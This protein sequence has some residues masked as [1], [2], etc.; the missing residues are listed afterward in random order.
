M[1]SQLLASI[2]LPTFDAAAT[3]GACLA[4]VARQ[5]ERR[6]ECLIVDDG[7]RDESAAIVG[8]IR[9]KDPRFRWLSGP[10]EGLVP[11][12]NRGLAQCR[13]PLV[14]RMDADDLMHR[15]RLRWQLELM[16]RQPELSGC[17]GHVHLFPRSAV[18]AGMRR[19]QAWLRSI[20]SSATVEREA[21]VE[22]PLAHPTLALRT[23]VLRSFGYRDQG[24]PEDWDLI[25]RLL[26]RG[27]R[28]GVLPRRLLFWRQSPTR[29]SRT[30]PAYSLEAFMACR[31]SFLAQGFLAANEQYVL[32]GYGDTGKALR[33]ALAAHGKSP[34][35]IVELHPGRLGQKIFGAP[36]V[37]PEALTELRP[38]RILVSVAGA[39]ARGQIRDALAAMRLFEGHDYLCCA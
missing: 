34:S 31:A 5:S 12:L 38:A 22:C 27:H 35:H 7:S 17:G 2:L 16:T 11:T 37:A 26:A 4:S 21:F 33:K 3:L 19:Y 15:H 6:F 14:V 29:L 10:H 20:D 32:W 30:H 36:V 24:W 18:D 39:T 25:L 1:M 8:R 9:E 23:E 13:A 28:L